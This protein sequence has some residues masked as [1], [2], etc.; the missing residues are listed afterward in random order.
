MFGGWN[1]ISQKKKIQ[2]RKWCL[3]YLSFASFASP[4]CYTTWGL[5]LSCF[6]RD[7]VFSLS[8]QLIKIG[9]KFWVKSS[10]TSEFLG[11]D[12]SSDSLRF[13]RRVDPSMGPT[14]YFKKLMSILNINKVLLQLKLCPPTDQSYEK[15]V[16]EGWVN[17]SQMGKHFNHQTGVHY[18][19][20]CWCLTYHT[21]LISNTK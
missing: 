16:I 14:P 11:L 10:W 5:I 8:Y 12:L 4:L 2:F 9:K 19:A 3:F 1:P 21:T 17:S 13:S 20:S 18:F 7:C 6:S 15:H